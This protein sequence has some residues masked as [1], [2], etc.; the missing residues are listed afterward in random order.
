[1]MTL[2]TLRDARELERTRTEPV[3]SL[4]FPLGSSI[5]GLEV[6]GASHRLDRAT[7][8]LVPARV[9]YELSAASSVVSVVVLLV[10]P[11]ERRAARREYE[12]DF[13]LAAFDT[14]VASPR[15]LSRTRWVD[16][17]VH[18][19]VFE[20][21]VCEKHE[22]QAARF[23]ETELT[24]ELFFLGKEQLAEETRASVLHE[25]RDVVSR[26]RAW[27][28]ARLFEPLSI[29]EL[30]RHCGSSESTLLRAFR[31]DVGMPPTA[32]LRNRRLEEA[33]LL[34]ESGRY[35]VSEVAMRVGYAN[36]S[37]FTAAFGRRFGSSPSEALPKAAKRLPPHGRPP[38][39]RRAKK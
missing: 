15:R 22:S 10:G 1:M 7:F 26:A 34:L 5:V 24:K 11:E 18:R 36:I 28:E 9:P 14:I 13:V 35:N 32:Y 29:V 17:L 31:R 33:L 23:L 6:G 25:D 2:R 39:R 16:E 4:V 27:L 8:G 37:A 20:R 38:R 30:A 19:Y 3:P 21:T 12:P